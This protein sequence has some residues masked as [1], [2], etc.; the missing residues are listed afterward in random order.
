MTAMETVPACPKKLL[1]YETPHTAYVEPRCKYNELS[2]K[3]T[4]GALESIRPPLS[5]SCQQPCVKT[6]ARV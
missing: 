6:T 4:H 2:V 5:A 1:K 3:R